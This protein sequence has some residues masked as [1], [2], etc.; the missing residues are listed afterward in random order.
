MTKEYT[1]VVLDVHF[2]EYQKFV[3]NCEIHNK[4]PAEIMNLFI[5]YFNFHYQEE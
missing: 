1:K 2:L 4:K 3:K 5:K